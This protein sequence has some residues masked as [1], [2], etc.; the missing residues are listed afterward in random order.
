MRP[1]TRRGARPGTQA[2]TSFRNSSLSLVRFRGK[3]LQRPSAAA[4]RGEGLLRD[5]RVGGLDL[6][7]APVREDE[8]HEKAGRRAVT[9]RVDCEGERFADLEGA[10]A[11]DADA[12]QP[13]DAERFNRV[14]LDLVAL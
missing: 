8:G 12:P 2:A 14:M 13:E 6:E 1:A 4:P 9:A 10:L 5:R 7:P 11:V 3:P